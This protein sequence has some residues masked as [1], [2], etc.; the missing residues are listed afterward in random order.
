MRLT[1]WGILGRLQLSSGMASCL[2]EKYFCHVYGNEGKESLSPLY[3][4]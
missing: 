2:H 1:A 3:G 4:N